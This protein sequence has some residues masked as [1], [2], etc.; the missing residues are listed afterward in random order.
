MTLSIWHNGSVFADEAD[1][2]TG[3]EAERF[4]RA[5]S[6]YALDSGDENTIDSAV[7]SLLR[8]LGVHD[9]RNL[10]T[11]ELW[12]ARVSRNDPQ[13]M[14]FP[15][16]VRRDG[17]IVNL[18]IKAKDKGGFGFHGLMPGTSGSGKSEMCL[19]CVYSLA[20]THSPT[21]AQVVYV[22]M[23]FE[24]AAQDL[25]GLPHVA[26][27][28]SNLGNDLRHQAERM[29]RTL[30][31]EMERRYTLFQSVG[32][33][34]LNEYEEIRLAREAN[35]TH[36]LEPVPVMWIICDEYLTLFRK[37][38]KWSDFIMEIGEKGRGANM[39]FILCG[40]RLDLQS[41]RKF[42]DNIGYRIVLR[43]E[44][45]SSSREWTQGSDAAFY[46]PSE[47]AGHALLKVG[48]RDLVPFRCFYLSGPFVVPKEERGEGRTTVELKFEEPRPLTVMHQELPGLD[49]ELAMAAPE[50][51][52]DEYLYH[53]EARTKR[54]RMLD[55]VRESIIGSDYRVPRTIWYEPL[56]VPE[57]VD[58]LVRRWRGNKPWHEDYGNNPGLTLLAGIEDIPDGP[59]GQEQA[60]YSLPIEG[61]N[62][63]VV[64]TKNM[65]KTTT[66]LTLVTSGCLLYQPNRLTF[67]CIGESAMF[68]LEEW[69]HVA[70]VVGRED[71]EGVKRILSTLEA[72]KESRKQAFQKAKGMT[73]Q[74]FR[75][76]RFGGV[77]GWTDPADLFGDLCLVIDDFSGFYERYDLTGIAERAINLAAE[78][79]SYGIHLIVSQS[80][81]IHGQ[82][83]ALKNSSN[84]RIELRLS[85]PGR[86][87]MEDREAARHLADWNHPGFAI[88]KSTAGAP[89]NEMLIGVPEIEIADPENP[90][91]T[92]RLA[93]ADAATVVAKVAGTDK[94]FEVKRLPKSEPLSAVTEASPADGRWIIPFAIGE[95][96]LQP[97][98]L[99][100]DASPNALAVG[101]KGCGKDWLLETIMTVTAERFTPEQVLITV[102]DPTGSLRDAVSR[103]TGG[104]LRAYN[105]TA[106]DITKDLMALGKEL[107]DRL[108]PSGLKP[109]ELQ[110][111]AGR[112]SGPR[113]MVI[114]NDEDM[115]G[116]ADQSLLEPGSW[117]VEQ[118][119]PLALLMPRAG[120]IGLHVIAARHTG[121][122]DGVAM[123]RKFV[124]KM[125]DSRAPILFMDNTPD[126]SIKERVRAESLPQGR[127]LL[128][129]AGTVEGILV[130]YP[131]RLVDKLPLFN[132]RD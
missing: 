107:S 9:P 83:Q 131:D 86:T 106:D 64:G 85:D 61:D 44:S 18:I 39:F 72:I 45:P 75:E 111:W 40:Q 97:V 7:A 59:N 28:L 57:P 46:L 36:D 87:E 71:V 84:A 53:D 37:Y 29:R 10:N 17:Q 77:E 112:T 115:L 70:A 117:G 93:A 14:S 123:T 102:V 120:E 43:A 51:T 32:A 6:Q 25:R 105:Y 113:H 11:E 34:D 100:L 63:M 108:P 90:E 55:V 125:I 128:L 73:I 38:P 65:G 92:R 16:G 66:L 88:T 89:S 30:L 5:M 50:S 56:E 47:D 68:S 129:N 19:V 79:P 76:R 124:K 119:D 35:G 52:P 48:E 13:W 116:E 54:K 2:V 110:A 130:G 96:A 74:Q 114:I 12:A 23:K 95:T 67:M 31:G 49:E 94:Y 27:A 80:D 127:G 98:C 69:P 22:D 121:A 109:H 41:I 8:H 103:L 1:Q 33:R 99:N 81:W 26:A 21:T 3:D 20:L 78:G 62:V 82:S 104:H 60:V 15:V 4:A 91:A 24:S 101:L 118:T 132:E 122:W 126:T 58:E 42:E